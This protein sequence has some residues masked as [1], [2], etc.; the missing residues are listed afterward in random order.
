M[1]GKTEN[2]VI[3]SDEEATES[4]M[5]IRATTHQVMFEKE[6][7][8]YKFA[9]VQHA[10]D[11][12]NFATLVD[13]FKMHNPTP[14]TWC[15][16][17]E[18]VLRNYLPRLRLTNTTTQTKKTINVYFGVVGNEKDIPKINIHSEGY[19]GVTSDTVFGRSDSR[20]TMEWKRAKSKTFKDA[21]VANGSIA[22]K[23]LKFEASGE[24]ALDENVKYVL[25]K[26]YFEFF[27]DVGLY[28]N[29]HSRI[30]IIYLSMFQNVH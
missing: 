7:T 2:S 18:E 30:N 17:G 1:K 3:S 13:K 25:E 14:R 21:A 12:V 10:F 20:A 16:G 29:I 6:D 11:G 24:E 22:Y 19:V 9:D 5:Y 28:L 4:P 15:E 8:P 27:K 23:F 26:C